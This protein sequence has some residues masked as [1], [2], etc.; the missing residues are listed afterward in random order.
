V[1]NVWIH[2]LIIENFIE[3]KIWQKHRVRRYEVEEALTHRQAI[4]LRHKRDPVRIV[5]VGATHTG[6]MLKIVLEFQGKGRY[7]LVT[8]M[9]LNPKEKRQYGKKIKGRT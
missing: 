2:R 8:A 1:P 6:R 7:F 9:D 3:E 5:A 4:R